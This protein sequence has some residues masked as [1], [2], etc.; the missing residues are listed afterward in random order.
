MRQR[1]GGVVTCAGQEVALVPATRY[2]SERMRATYGSTGPRAAVLPTY[3]ISF[4]PDEPEF[5][6]LARRTRCDAQ[7]FFAFDHLRPGSYFVTTRVSWTVANRQQ[8][9][10]LMVRVDVPDDQA[11]PARIVMTD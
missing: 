5:R 2:A 10:L 8:G 11:G 4:T 9:Q 6:V 7:G 1:G 3:T